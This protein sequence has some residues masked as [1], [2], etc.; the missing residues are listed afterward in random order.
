MNLDALIT[1]AQA[2]RL[3][4]VTRANVC[5]WVTAGKLTAKRHRGRSPLYRLGDVLA[6]E[7]ETRQS[8]KSHRGPRTAA[9]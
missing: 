1:G 5:A 8:G 9:A 4:N 6:V 2:A 7:R 3:A